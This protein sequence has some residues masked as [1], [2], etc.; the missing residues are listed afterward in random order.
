MFLFLVIYSII[1]MHFSRYPKKINYFKGVYLLLALT[2][3]FQC[4][5]KFY[6][7]AC[8]PSP[9]FLGYCTTINEIGFIFPTQAIV[10]VWCLGCTESVKY[11]D[12]EGWGIW[13][14]IKKKKKNI[15]MDIPVLLRFFHGFDSIFQKIIVIHIPC[16]TYTHNY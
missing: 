6:P 12:S 10:S 9:L 2:V 15:I 8:K 3:Y 7:F 1:R 16:I 14:F 13:N 5:L 4:I 11:L